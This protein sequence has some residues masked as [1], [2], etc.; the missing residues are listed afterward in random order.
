MLTHPL[1]LAAVVVLS[2]LAVWV[3]F[4]ISPGNELCAPVS[5][6]SVE[7]L[8]APCLVA[9]KPIRPLDGFAATEPP[10]S[11]PPG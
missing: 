11:I 4:E 1:T 6:R 3:A 8:F 2:I 9:A 10:D 7:T 5:P